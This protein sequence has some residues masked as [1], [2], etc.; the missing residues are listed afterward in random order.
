M[1]RL[2]RARGASMR[3]CGLTRAC[4]VNPL[5]IRPYA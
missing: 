1:T 5:G 4:D 3:S 2:L